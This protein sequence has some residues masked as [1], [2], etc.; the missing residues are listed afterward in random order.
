MKRQFPLIFTL[1]SIVTIWLA[2]I[3]QTVPSQA[4]K[5]T[6]D[7][8]FGLVQTYDD[9]EAA[10][11]SGAGFTRIKLY[12]D[13]IQPNGPADWRPSNVP[14]PLVE[15]DLAAGREVVG[16]IV[17]TPAWARDLNHPGNNPAN[18]QLKDVPDMAAWS[19]FV[20]K[21]VEQYEG[22]IHH[23]IIWNE[24]DVWEPVHP[25]STWNG[26]EEDYF[27]LLKTA[28]LS[29]KDVDPNAQVYIS[30]F[31][32]W[33]DEEYKREQYLSRLLKIIKADPQA[34][35]NNYYFDGVPYHLYYK[36]Q[37]LQ[38]I[39]TEVRTLLDSYDLA[40][41]TI[42]LNETNAPPSSDPTEPPHKEPRFKADLDEQSSFI[43]Q[44]HA[45]AFAAGAERV[46]IYKL[47][48]SAEH[49]EDVQP[50]G[51]LRGDKSRRPAFTAYQVVT[52]YLSG[53]DTATLYEQGDVK[54]VV[55][56]RGAET[57]TIA[58]T[59]APEVRQI[60]LNAIG[61]E[62]LLV[63]QRGQTQT[64]SPELGA[65]TLQLPAAICSS[66]DCF[67]GGEPQILVE[68]GSPS[69]RQPAAIQPT[70]TPSPTPSPTVYD[71]MEVSPRRNFVFKALNL[72]ALAVLVLILIRLWFW[73]RRT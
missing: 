52:Q 27:E 65:Y 32:Y 67:I 23:W 58:W 24:P 34:A 61:N 25:G 1:L 40:D 37:Q 4:Q 9:L 10:A 72:A 63:D 29:L 13:I 66:G 50:F 28:Y 43:I 16:L 19:T 42:W 39:I 21:L 30:G 71:I 45:I 41:K 6:P 47:F 17:H 73:M 36:P 51:L 49:P 26:N 68:Q 12:W 35:E 53:F 62:A 64:I 31:T 20:G 18:P 56:E 54:I 48:N 8:R 3:F 33:W 22:K 46:Q 69:Q 57:I 38:D 14:D 15:A 44:A 70:P 7:P 60:T 2:T 55:F 5:P 59:M 11:E